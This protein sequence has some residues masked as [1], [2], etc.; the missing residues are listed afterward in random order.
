MSPLVGRNLSGNGDHLVF[1]METTKS[2]FPWLIETGYNGRVDVNGIAGDSSRASSPPG[3][4]VTCMI[5]IRGV[6]PLINPLSKYVIQDGCIP[7][8]FN[9]VILAMLTIQTVKSQAFSFLS[10]PRVGISKS[11][12]AFKSLLLGPYARG[13]SLQRTST[14]LVMSHDSN[15][16]TLTLEN[17]TL[18]LRGPAEGRTEHFTPMK[19]M[20]KRLFAH[21]GA[22]MGFSYFYGMRLSYSSLS[23]L[24]SH[25]SQGRHQEEVTVHL[26]GG[27]NM[28]SDGT[29]H[30]GVTNHLGQVFAGPGPGDEVYKD[31]VCCDAS[32][33][34]TALGVNPL[35]TISALSERSISL[36][37]EKSGLIIDQTE[38]G[39]LDA[40]SNPQMTRNGEV[41]QELMNENP[42]SIGWQFTETLSGHI[43]ICQIKAQR[44]PSRYQGV[45]TGTVSCHALS[46]N[47]LRV[48]KGTVDFFTG[49]AGAE[50]TI[51]YYMKL[52]SVEDLEYYLEGHKILNSSIAFSVKKTWKATTTVNVNITR[53]DG[54]QAGSGALHISLPEFTKQIRTF[55]TKVVDRS[56]FLALLAFLLSFLYHVSLFFF[57]PFV[58]VRFPRTS[59]LD[60]IK[61]SPNPS[62]ISKISASDDV[63]TLLEVYDPLLQQG[64]HEPRD[65]NFPPVLLLPGITGIGAIHNLYALPFLR[66]N[67][68]DYFTQRGHRCYTL[69]PR[70]GCD[71]IVAQDATIFDCR[72]DVAAAIK[73]IREI[74][75][76]KPYVISHCQ[77]SVALCMGLLDG[78]ISSSDLLGIT[79]N[80]VFMNQVFGYWNS[81]KGRTTLLIQLYKLLAGNY[82]PI[83]SNAGSALFQ[84]L[85][86]ILLRFYPVGHP[87][88]LCTSTA[89]HRTSFAFGLLWNHDNLD[90]ALHDNIHQFFA[91]THTKLMEHVVGM[92]TRGICMD[93]DSR[94]LLTDENLQRLEGLPILFVS[95]TGN[96]VFDP[97]ST[98]KDYELLRRR[99]GESFYRR[100]LAEGYGHLDTIVGKSAAEDVYWRMFAHLK[101]CIENKHM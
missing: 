94:S 58:P 53:P 47:T 54:T 36:I 18:R 89:C 56:S 57:M 33:L 48:I 22:D 59:P 73:Y 99:F 7:E 49:G 24:F 9:P 45:C 82:F 78:T 34:P 10:N 11:M 84:R 26:I 74:E 52:L 95:G 90:A 1:G 60:P 86:D 61:K 42:Q 44:S 23:K 88:D 55:R 40:S 76:N 5:D 72:L 13:G 46:R 62:L 15:E 79:A 6:D 30:G 8:T 51:S 3:P 29:A 83:I 17:D 25:L 4:T 85:L 43:N 69:T 12:A 71:P 37:A 64:N 70:W 27:A 81:L 91:G 21:T 2:K 80:S 35:A 31:L 98:L 75:P 92:G 63:P 32:I 41:Y 97:Q 20:V 28:S 38:N 67:M 77:G 50:C 16:I 101:W 87:R 68:I 66:C 96:Q 100:F 93:N 19:R 39:P 14:Y 65:A